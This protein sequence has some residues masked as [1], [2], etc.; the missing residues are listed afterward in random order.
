MDIGVLTV[1][2][3]NY[4]PNRRLQEAA[5]AKGLS[6][7]LIDPRKIAAGIDKGRLRIGGLAGDKLP[8]VILPRQGAQISNASIVVLSH[9]QAAGIP[10]VNALASV[11][12][13]RNKFATLQV[14]AANGVRV[15]DSI[16]V[17]SGEAFWGAVDTLG[18]YPL[19]CKKTAGRKGREVFLA[20]NPASAQ[21][22]VKTHLSNGEGLILQQFIPPGNGRRDFRVMVIG[23]T[24]AA[25]MEMT[26]PEGDFR[27]NFGISGSSRPVALSATAKE[28]AI[29]CARA[30]GLGIA[31]VDLIETGTNGIFA[32]EANYAPGFKGLEMATG[33]DIAA[34]IIDFTATFLGKNKSMPGA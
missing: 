26:V 18:G 20:E 28:M 14:L 23:G 22:I 15:P 9:F 16:F 25:A 11:L 7:A 21:A 27:S 10:I 8:G 17:N 32:I 34:M 4:H 30:T 31:G 24:V 5:S 3:E 2:D 33:L 1:K 12:T 6:L 13:A 29:R 19:V